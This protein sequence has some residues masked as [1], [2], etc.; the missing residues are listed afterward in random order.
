MLFYMLMTLIGQRLQSRERKQ[1]EAYVRSLNHMYAH[2][3]N[4]RKIKCRTISTQHFI[5]KAPKVD[6]RLFSLFLR[7][8]EDEVNKLCNMQYHSH[9]SD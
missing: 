9:Y 7:K 6:S 3:R 4:E 5:N 8:K 1:R 2:L